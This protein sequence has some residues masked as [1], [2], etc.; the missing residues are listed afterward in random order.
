[1]LHNLLCKTL[2]LT[3]RSIPAKATCQV[4]SLLLHTLPAL[5]FYNYRIAGN[6]HIVQTFTVF[7]DGPTTAK[8]KTVKV[9]TINDVMSYYGGGAGRT[10]AHVALYS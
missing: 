5:Y 6:F 2:L 7:A 8:I 3:L 9:L 1:M 10:R 4:E